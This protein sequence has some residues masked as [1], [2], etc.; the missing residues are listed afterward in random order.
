LARITHPP[1]TGIREARKVDVAEYV[2][3]VRGAGSTPI[4]M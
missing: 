4:T 1:A 2:I 3:V